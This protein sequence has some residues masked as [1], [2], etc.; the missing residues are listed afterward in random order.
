MK[1]DDASFSFEVDHVIHFIP[2]LGF[3]ELGGD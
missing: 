2:V 3:R 1:D